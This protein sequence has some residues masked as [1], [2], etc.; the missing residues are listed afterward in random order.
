MKLISGVLAVC[1]AMVLMVEVQ[2]TE[3]VLIRGRKTYL[4]TVVAGSHGE[5]SPSKRASVLEGAS[6]TYT[7]KP[8]AGYLIDSLTVNGAPQKSLPTTKGKSYTLKL[9]NIKDNVTINA[10]FTTKRSIKSLAVGSQV[11]VV[12]AKK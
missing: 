6:K 4:V 9:K 7:V 10:T 2:A 5:V 3:K 12:D 11:S 1:A 8:N